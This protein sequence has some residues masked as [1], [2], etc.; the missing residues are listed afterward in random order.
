[1]LTDQAHGEVF[2]SIS[3]T[4]LKEPGGGLFAAFVFGGRFLRTNRTCGSW[5]GFGF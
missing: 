1:L 3:I 2:E 4:A 5:D